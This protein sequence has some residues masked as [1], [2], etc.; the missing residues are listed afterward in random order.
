MSKE[1][2]NLK[3]LAKQIN[4]DFGGGSLMHLG[5]SPKILENE[6]KRQS[7]GYKLL[8]DASA[9][10][11]CYGKIHEIF[12]NEGD[13]KTTLALSILAE[14]Q[15]NGMQGYY[16]DAEHKLNLEY[17]KT[18]GVDVSKLLITQPSHGEHA[19]DV[20]KDV[21]NSNLVNICV[22]D[23]VS[24]LTPLSMINGEFTDANMGAHA[25]LMSTM[26]RVLVPILNQKNIILILI[27]QIRYKLGV[28]FGCFHYNTLVNFA[29]G[30]NIPIGKVVDEKIQGDVYCLNE[31]TN[32]IEIK[33]IVDWHD[34]GKIENKEDFIHIQTNS[35][36]GGSRFGFTCTPN[37][38]I[39]T[40]KGWKQA[41]NINY[42][43]KLI[44]KYLETIN[45]TYGDFLRGILIGDS[46]ISI[47]DQ[48]T[49]CLR[50]QENKQ[51]EY[52]NWKLKKLNP[53]LKFKKIDINNRGYRYISKYTFEWSKIKKIIG[54]RNPEYM[55]QK[56]SDLSLAIWIMDD[57]HFDQKGGH[58]RYNISIKRFKNDDLNLQ[59]VVDL[60]QKNGLD[61]NYRISDGNINFSTE[62]TDIIAKRICKFVPI[63]M[64]YKLPVEYHEKYQEF[65][66][67]NK[68][69]EIT[70]FVEIKEIRGASNKQ[71]KNKRKFDIS[72][73][74]NENY[75]VGGKY[76]GIIVHNSP[77]TTTGGQAIKFHSIMRMKLTSTKY[78][79]SDKLKRMV[80]VNFIKQQ[81]GGL[82]Y[83]K[84][85]L[86]LNIG[87]GFDK[88]YDLIEH[89]I[90]KGIL[91]LNG[92]QV[93]MGDISIGQGKLKASQNLLE[94][95]KLFDKYEKLLK[96]V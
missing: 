67:R 62:M 21:F 35:I 66:L 86:L 51:V 55:L 28:M 4:K 58:R 81:S 37:H 49:G 64:Q 89:G 3:N 24:S 59:N 87:E 60:F 68:P 47:R 90:K 80:N 45:G 23:S 38:K 8:D 70:E 91:K 34:N 50:F 48:N 96:G 61:C 95:K 39:L 74:D 29:D 53:F 9:G 16:V 17:A 15:R 43:D 54:N 52:L 57:G 2:D 65:N 19:L 76:N 44:S 78:S 92:S 46:H 88:G 72:V 25:R 56:Y 75:M 42:E 5:D 79:D 27:N 82:P 63:C 13:G 40:N 10:G 73:Q 20:M 84:T 30:K 6:A 71:I 14:C 32:E 1:I 36:D 31:K 77:E 12:G 93:K 94:D 18:L 85:G 11:L 69:I 7:F 26:C 83:T 22:V 41:K 33:S